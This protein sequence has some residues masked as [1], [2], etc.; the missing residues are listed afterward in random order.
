MSFEWRVLL[1]GYWSIKEHYSW[2]VLTNNLYVIIFL[3]LVFLIFQYLWSW[4][5]SHIFQNI[6]KEKQNKIMF[7]KI[8]RGILD[9][10]VLVCT[11]NLSKSLSIKC[12]DFNLIIKI[13]SCRMHI[14][15]RIQN[16]IWLYR[17]FLSMAKFTCL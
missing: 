9:S 5:W 6:N 17:M 10:R 16:I 7:N 1:L 11:S 14:L 12:Q 8:T 2:I 13:I 15:W 4:K 3:C